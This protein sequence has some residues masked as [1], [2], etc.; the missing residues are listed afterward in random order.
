MKKIYLFSYNDGTK[1]I[2]GETRNI[3]KTMGSLTY[4][5]LRGFKISNVTFKSC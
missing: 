1:V 4:W 2:T 3:A 5:A